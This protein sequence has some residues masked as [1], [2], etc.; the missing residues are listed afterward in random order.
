MIYLGE[1][2]MVDQI[3]LFFSFDIGF[4]LI[5]PLSICRKHLKN[6]LREQHLRGHLPVELP[7]P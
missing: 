3:F 1:Y 4:I 2:Y 6:T 7:M 5:S